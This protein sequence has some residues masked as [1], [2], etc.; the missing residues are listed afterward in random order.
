[1][2]FELCGLQIALRFV[3]PIR[4]LSTCDFCG[5][6]CEQPDCENCYPA[7]IVVAFQ[8][9]LPSLWLLAH[10]L[11]IAGGLAKAYQR[12]WEALGDNIDATTAALD[13][14][15]ARFPSQTEGE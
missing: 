5:G 10:N 1:M 3:E 14:V 11:A 13:K 2:R 4:E 9:A 8:R 15:G 6:G 12:G 7:P